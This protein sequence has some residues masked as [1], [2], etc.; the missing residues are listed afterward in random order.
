VYAVSLFVFGKA[1]KEVLDRI[2]YGLV[3]REGELVDGGPTN[4]F[5]R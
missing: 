1:G 3:A 2:E 4:I 5:L